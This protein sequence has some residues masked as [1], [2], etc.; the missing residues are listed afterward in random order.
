MNF[1]R[2]TR[3]VDRVFLHCSASDLPEHDSV[4]IMRQWHK[5]RGWRDV[6][7]H[8]FIRKDGVIEDGRS[9]EET[10]AAQQGHNTGTIA[11]CLHGLKR[12]NFTKAQFES[13]I[14]LCQAIDRAYDNQ[15]TFHGHCEVSA[16]TC[17]VFDYKTVLGLTDAGERKNAT[18]SSVQAEDQ[19]MLELTASGAAVARLQTLLNEK[20]NLKLMIDGRFGQATLRAVLQ[21]QRKEG[22]MDDGIVGKNTWKALLKG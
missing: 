16:K 3:P 19:P 17:P 14:A 10:P 5:E 13:V 20:L 7:Y 15:L 22:L 11:I 1:S 12:E 6:G 4:E 18:D 21:F 2:P 8:Y 9:L